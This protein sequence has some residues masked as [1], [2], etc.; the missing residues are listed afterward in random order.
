MDSIK[1]F[2]VPCRLAGDSR[3]NKVFT[4]EKVLYPSYIFIEMK[5]NEIT[6]TAIRDISRVS[7]FVGPRKPIGRGTLS[8]VMPKR[9]SQAEVERFEGLVAA[10]GEK[11]CK[12]QGAED[13]SYDATKKYLHSTW[14]QLLTW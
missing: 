11:W 13:D 6:Y 5:L 14:L 8:M 7:S 4:S 1:Q 10:G 2:C 9:L 3:M 12:D